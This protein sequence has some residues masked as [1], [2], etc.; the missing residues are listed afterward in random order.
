MKKDFNNSSPQIIYVELD[1][2]QNF[3]PK[4]QSR[5]LE[6]GSLLTPEL[7]DMFPFLSEKEIKDSLI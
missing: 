7:H 6:D 1:E 2:K 4:L 5:K 3:E